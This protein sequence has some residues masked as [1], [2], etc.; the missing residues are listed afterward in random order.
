VHTA[1]CV[2]ICAKAHTRSMSV[3]KSTS[4]AKRS[5]TKKAGAKR[6]QSDG[7]PKHPAL[8]GIASRGRNFGKNGKPCAKHEIF[9]VWLKNPATFDVKAVAKRFSGRV[10]ESTIRSWVSNWSTGH[11]GKESGGFYPVTLEKQLG[12]LP[13]LK[14]ALAKLKS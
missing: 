2:R 9:A 6:K 14:K 8:H 1:I 11:Q 12:G 10:K 7:A 4:T 3:K 5:S 13:A